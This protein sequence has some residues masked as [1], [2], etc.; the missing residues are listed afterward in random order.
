M[1]NFFLYCWQL[2]LKKVCNKS[3]FI[4]VCDKFLPIVGLRQR[5][6]SESKF[7]CKIMTDIKV[8]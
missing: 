8:S 6:R 3:N 2:S 1:E 5:F 4:K 7:F